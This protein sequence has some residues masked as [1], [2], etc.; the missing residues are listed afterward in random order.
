MDI[1]TIAKKLNLEVRSAS[2]RLKNNVTGGYTGIGASWIKR[3]GFTLRAL[4]HQAEEF[5]R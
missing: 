5:A 2:D 4:L 3:S 1:E